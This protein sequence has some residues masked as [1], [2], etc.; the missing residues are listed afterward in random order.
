VKMGRNALLAGERLCISK[1]REHNGRTPGSP[2]T[3]CCNG[4]RSF[5]VGARL[6]IFVGARSVVYRATVSA[7]RPLK[8]V[9][10][11]MAGGWL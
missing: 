9:L 1:Y 11:S 2:E 7:R 8:G 10:G 6:D 4:T 5:F 3:S